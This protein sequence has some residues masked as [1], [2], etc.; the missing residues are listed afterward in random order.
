MIVETIIAGLTAVFVSSLAFAH[1]QIKHQRR[2]EVEDLERERKWE[3]EDNAPP[4][5]P[6]EPEPE[7]TIDPF[8]EMRIGTPC[9]KCLIPAKD[10]IMDTDDYG[11]PIEAEPAQG[12]QLPKACTYSTRCKAGK[13]PHLHAY[14]NTCGMSWFMQPADQKEKKDDN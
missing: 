14:C 3:E 11:D 9:P 13:Y 2:V 10:A 8:V 7:P 5:P 12:P 4:P 6:P 1:A